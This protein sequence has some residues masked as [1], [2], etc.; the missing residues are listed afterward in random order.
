MTS[1]FFDISNA[2]RLLVLDQDEETRDLV[3]GVLT[4]EGVDV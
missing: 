3:C 1:D 2:A 4:E